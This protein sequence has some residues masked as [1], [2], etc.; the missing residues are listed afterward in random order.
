MIVLRELRRSRIQEC[1]GTSD[2]NDDVEFES[3]A[4]RRLAAAID[5]RSGL[6]AP[7]GPDLAGLLR[8]A[9]RHWGAYT[10][11]SPSL[12]IPVARWPGLRLEVL[13]RHGLVATPVGD[14]VV[15][16]ATHGPRGGSTNPRSGIDHDA[17]AGLQRR[18]E[19][20]VEAGPFFHHA[21]GYESYR[22]PGQRA[23]PPSCRRRTLW[24]TLAVVLP[25]GEGKSACFYAAA[26]IGWSDRKVSRG[27]VVVVTPTI[28][29]ALDHERNAAE[30]GFD[31][32]T[33]A[34]RAGDP[35]SQGIADRLKDGTQGI[36]F[37]SPE[38]SLRVAAPRSPVSGEVGADLSTRG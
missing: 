25:T 17:A 1:A 21:L 32:P 36:L 31:A 14:E 6:D 5:T 2:T 20:S 15:L 7:G 13:A 10:G 28:A 33:L 19:V 4:F 38:R 18:S 16:H 29:L 3:P 24:A 22:S 9:L 27:T 8:Y 12:A 11:T 26:R 30:Y 35:A 37:T 34:F 23:A